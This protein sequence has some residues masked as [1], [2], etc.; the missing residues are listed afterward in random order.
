MY[1]KCG[2]T[3]EALVKMGADEFLK[4]IKKS[5]W[6]FRDRLVGQ[7][8]PDDKRPA[9]KRTFDFLRL[10]GKVHCKSEPPTYDPNLEPIPA[11]TKSVALDEI[12]SL[13]ALT[14]PEMFEVLVEMACLNATAAEIGEQAG[15]SHKQAEAV[16]LDRC[17][18]AILAGVRAFQTIDRLDEANEHWWRTIPD[19]AVVPA[20]AFKR[21]A[22]AHSMGLAA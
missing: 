10:E 17:R 13:W 22:E 11:L 5:P 21:L 18:L 8:G 1:I 14:S 20:S 12:E 3:P 16:G 4:Q 9:R 19:S 15:F 7:R 2:P 6:L